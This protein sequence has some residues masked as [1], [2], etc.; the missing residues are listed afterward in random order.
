MCFGVKCHEKVNKNPFQ[1]TVDAELQRR[2]QSEK[3]RGKA[4]A[5]VICVRFMMDEGRFSRKKASSQI[6]EASV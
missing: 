3:E 2:S 6:G 5:R 4:S 1:Y